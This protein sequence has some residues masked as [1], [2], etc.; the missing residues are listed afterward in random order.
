MRPQ[1]GITHAIT[2]KGE[3]WFRGS[4][5]RRRGG[6]ELGR[7]VVMDAKSEHSLD[8]PFDPGMMPLL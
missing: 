7:D 4:G 2:T 5:D 6:K 1:L 8:V 3:A